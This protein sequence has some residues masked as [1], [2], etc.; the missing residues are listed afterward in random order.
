[1]C[2]AG[3]TLMVEVA[4]SFEER[5]RGLM[6]RDTL[7]ENQG[8]LFIFP[9]PQR[10]SFWM[11]NTYIPLSLAYIGS[12]WVIK[13]IYDLQPLDE[14]PVISQKPVMYAL[15]VTQGWFRRHAVGVGDTVK[16]PCK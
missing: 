14:R 8:M 3:E 13:E 1:M 5:R 11:K 16:F 15:E 4:R 7:L 6:F 9:Y 2:V 12:D 10:L